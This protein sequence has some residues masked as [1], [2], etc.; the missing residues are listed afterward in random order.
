MALDA[1]SLETTDFFFTLF[2]LEFPWGGNQ[3]VAIDG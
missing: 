3:T 2:W 1:R